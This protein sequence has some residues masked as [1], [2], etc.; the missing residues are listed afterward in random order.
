MAS[1]STEIMADDIGSKDITLGFEHR[2]RVAK[3]Q[4]HA[5]SLDLFI[6]S[7]KKF[8]DGKRL[9]SL[10]ALQARIKNISNESANSLTAVQQGSMERAD[11]EG[12]LTNVEQE[13]KKVVDF[14]GIEL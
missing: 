10:E 11:L 13:L 1:A 7:K 2:D 6:E 8:A 9:Q 3:M 4:E 14:F 5:E 12:V